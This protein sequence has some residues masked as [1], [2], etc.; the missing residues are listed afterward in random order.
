MIRAH[1]KISLSLRVLG[2]RADGFHD[3]DALTVG[4]REPFDTI[5]VE[6][7][8]ALT[9]AVTGAF[10]ESVPVDDTNLVMQAARALERTLRIELDKGVPTQA[11]LGGGSADAAALLRAFDGSYDLASQLGSDVPF[12]MQATPA[13]MRGRGEILERVSVPTLHV[14]VAAPPFGCSTPAVYRAWDEL[15]GPQSERVIRYPG[16]GEDVVNDLEPAAE[17]VEP[18]L[19]AFRARLEGAIGCPAMLS[20]SGS[21]Y[22]AGF[23]VAADAYAAADA[24]RTAGI[25]SVWATT[26]VAG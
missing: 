12:F 9:L 10:A 11:G 14:I 25:T 18:R 16:L 6:A 4:V 1:A 13:R 2:T 15:G 17:H 7:S 22:S 26:T 20:G 24:A 21:A 3:I 5:R 8:D 23:A 19:R